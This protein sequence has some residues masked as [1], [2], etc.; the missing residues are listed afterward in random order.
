MKITS[1][2][3]LCHEFDKEVDE[4][5]TRERVDSKCFPGVF[6]NMHSVQKQKDTICPLVAFSS[7]SCAFQK[8]KNNNW[9]SLPLTCSLPEINVTRGKQTLI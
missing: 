9:I 7:E 5:V 6:L 4:V 8:W 2:L 1:P 3:F